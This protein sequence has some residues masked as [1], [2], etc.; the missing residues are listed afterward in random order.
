[1]L[2]SIYN[3]FDFKKTEL[4]TIVHW[5]PELRLR[6]DLTLIKFRTKKTDSDSTRENNPDPDS[7]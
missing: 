7:T 1:M 3:P 5:K 2:I 6:V 4:I